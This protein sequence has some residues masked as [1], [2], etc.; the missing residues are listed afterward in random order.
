MSNS[1]FH[2]LGLG[3]DGESDL[4]GVSRRSLIRTGATAAV[5]VPL[6]TVAT[7]APALAVS[8][9][10]TISISTAGITRFNDTLVLSLRL[11]NVGALQ[12]AAASI[13]TVSLAPAVGT[14]YAKRPQRIATSG[15]GWKFG[16]N[17]GAPDGS[18]PWT[19]TLLHAGKVKP[20]SSTN[21]VKLTLGVGKNGFESIFGSFPKSVKNPGKGV[22]TINAAS[23]S[24]FATP[25]ELQ[26]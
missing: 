5:A 20:G 10:A 12:T 11:T 13:V 17:G 23:G 21:T 1:N 2:D 18:G 9:G 4:N 15:L 26:I 6:I 3:N 19:W 22:F 7:A 24:N 16:V 8:P 14:E 25:K